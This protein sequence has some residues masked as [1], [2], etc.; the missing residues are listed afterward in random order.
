MEEVTQCLMDGGSS[1]IGE[2]P[3]IHRKQGIDKLSTVNWISTR[4]KIKNL[5]K[6]TY[7]TDAPLFFHILTIHQI[8][9][10]SLLNEIAFRI[11]YLDI[12]CM[13]LKAIL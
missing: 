4:E 6:T 12:I 5:W 10:L 8:Q 9:N 3:K 1:F 13:D 11:V 7:K 2:R